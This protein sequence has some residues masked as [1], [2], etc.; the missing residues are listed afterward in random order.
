MHDSGFDTPARSR[1]VN[2]V[3]GPG[4]GGGSGGGGNK[5]NKKL[6]TP[7]SLAAPTIVPSSRESQLADLKAGAHGESLLDHGHGEGSDD[8]DDGDYGDDGDGNR[9]RPISFLGT[10]PEERQAALETLL[11]QAQAAAR[12]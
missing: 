7:G 5:A 4:G 2:V 8:S 12:R 9:G 3:C 11:G 6:G 1:P 10:S